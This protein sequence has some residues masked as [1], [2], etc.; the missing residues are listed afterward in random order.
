MTDMAIQP[1]MQRER[2]AARFS[3]ITGGGDRTKALRAAKRHSMLVRTLRLL[4]PLVALGVTGLYFLPSQMTVE[5]DGG[6]ASVDDVVISDGGL[7]MINPRI[8]GVHERHGVYD[9]RADTATQQVS[10]PD[11]ITLNTVQGELV[12][13]TGE[14]TVLV[15]PSGLF[16]SK[17][18]QLTFDT[19]LTIGGDAGY[20]GQLQTAT[21]YFKDNK[22]VSTDPVALAFRNTTINAEAMTFYSSEKRAIFTG[23]V[24]LHLEREPANKRGASAGAIAA[25]PAQQG[26]NGE[27]RQ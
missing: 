9:I 16:D 27:S 13:K 7:T 2:G 4:C 22:L 11:L 8:N 14:K 18:E 3:G 26:Q 24:R 17:K 25:R 15:A 20:S 21:A 19:G 12:S 5:V 6:Q 1:Q 23:N 10:N